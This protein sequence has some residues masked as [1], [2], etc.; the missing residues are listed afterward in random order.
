MNRLLSFLVAVLA[1]FTV[2]G[3]YAAA[4]QDASIET[5]LNDIETAHLVF[6]REEEKLARDTYVTLN[7]K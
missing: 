5:A 6:M 4:V 3:T 7:E 1:W 2:A